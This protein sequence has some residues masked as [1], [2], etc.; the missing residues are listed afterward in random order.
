VLGAQQQ[1]EAK[2]TTRKRTARGWLL[3]R[4]DIELSIAP[5]RAMV[6]QKDTGGAEK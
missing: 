4:V 2:D 6:W 5:E 1:N 3:F